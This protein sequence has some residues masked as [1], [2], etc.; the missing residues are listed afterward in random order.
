MAGQERKIARRGELPIWAIPQSIELAADAGF[1]DREQMARIAVAMIVQL[2]RTKRRCKGFWTTIPSRGPKPLE[3]RTLTI[4]AFDA[5]PN[6][7]VPT[8]S[9][10]HLQNFPVDALK[11]DRSFVTKMTTLQRERCDHGEGLLFSRPLD[12]DAVEQFLQAAGSK[13]SS[14]TAR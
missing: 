8:S 7:E 6:R 10:A 9:M 11:I 3:E 5:V 13:R 12:A 2:G 1:L 14:L 4:D